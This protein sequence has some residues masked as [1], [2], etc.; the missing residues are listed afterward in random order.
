[1]QAHK[2]PGRIQ[3]WLDAD[4]TGID[5]HPRTGGN[6]MPS[7]SLKFQDGDTGAV[8]FARLI[9]E[10]GAGSW[11]LQPMQGDNESHKSYCI[12]DHDGRGSGTAAP[13]AKLAT[14]QAKTEGSAAAEGMERV[15]MRAL[16]LT[17]NLVGGQI[18][19]ADLQVDR[20]ILS[21]S[22]ASEAR[23]DLEISEANE[24]WAPHEK[25]A[26]YGGLAEA[27]APFTGPLHE[28]VSGIGGRL[29]KVAIRVAKAA[30]LDMDKY[31]QVTDPKPD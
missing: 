10:T 20:R 12:W 22:E 13:T 28:V 6:G 26:F 2:I 14:P 1:M 15:A 8:V 27:M 5:V 3:A 17:E 30:G 16:D 7:V 11:R 31:G 9:E 24:E 18:E 21:E 19:R 25:L 23:A 4:A 29:K